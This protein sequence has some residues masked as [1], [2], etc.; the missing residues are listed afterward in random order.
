MENTRT[1][2][3][4]YFAIYEA[5][6]NKYFKGHYDDGCLIGVCF[7]DEVVKSTFFDSIR[8]A[9]DTIEGLTDCDP[10]LVLSVVKVETTS[11]ISFVN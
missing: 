8:K 10:M 4:E 2:T 7:V 6:H 3:S 11:K 9:N 1:Q 5:P